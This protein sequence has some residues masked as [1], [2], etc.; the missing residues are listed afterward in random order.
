MQSV[1]LIGVCLS[2]IHEEDRFNFILELNKHAVKNGFRLL[3]FN[4]CADMYEQSPES[5]EGASSVFRLIPYDKLSA[6]IIFPNIIYDS[7]IV[8][9]I[10][11]NCLKHNLP[12][13]SMD[14]EMEGCITFTF[15]NSKVFEKLCRHVIEDHHAKKLYMMAGFRDNV[16]SLERVQAFRRALEKN[17][18][19]FDE[20]NIGYGCFWEQ[21]TIEVLNKWFWLL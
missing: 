13:I 9:E 17:D 15:D 10:R 8:E 7:G 21:P 6:L 4:S 18:L 14:K 5:N 19:S 16:Y 11:L 3:I 2:T 1:K 12:L 20:N